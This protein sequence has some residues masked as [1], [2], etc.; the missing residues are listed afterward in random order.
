MLLKAKKKLTTTPNHYFSY[1]F[2]VVLYESPDQ[3]PGIFLFN[4]QT[5]LS[6]I[7]ALSYNYRYE[8]KKR[9][10]TDQLL[11]TK[12]SVVKSAIKAYNDGRL[13]L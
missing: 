11:D 1:H 12:K 2:L 5:G 13:R 7:S 9:N 3:N 8:Y 6:D 10:Q 4:F